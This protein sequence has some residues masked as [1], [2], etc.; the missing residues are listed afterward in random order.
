MIKRLFTLSLATIAVVFAAFAAN[1]LDIEGA[2]ATV[3]GV[4][5]KDLATGK[6]MVDYN[7]QIAMTP[8]SVTKAV[9]A[10]TA[11][12]TLGPDFRF[13][14]RVV[15]SGARS[16]ATRHR[17]DGNLVIKSSGDPT[18]GSDQFKSTA[19]FSDSIVA[20]LKRMGITHISG[21]IVI[22]ET[23]KDAGPVTTWQVD[24][25]AWPYGAGLFGFNWAGNCVRAYPM[26]GTTVP[27]SNLKFDVYTSEVD[28]TDII[29]GI[30]SDKVSIGVTKKNRQ[31]KAWN[32]ETTVPDPSV[33]YGKI[34][35][36]RLSAAG[37][38]I[39]TK[40]SA[41]T[42]GATIVYTYRSPALTDICRN[43][44]KRSDNLFA[45]GML[46]ALKPEASRSK[47]IAYEKDF[48]KDR[49]VDT[50]YIILQDGSG[51][52]RPNRLS[53]RFLG[54]MLEWMARSEYADAYVDFFPIAGIDGT[55]K[56]FAEKT[57]LKGRLAMKTG[58]VNAVQTYAGYKIDAQGKPTH[59]VVVMVNGFFCP[60]PA[61]RR[62]IEKLLLNTL[63]K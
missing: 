29:R 13:T 7:S 6:V 38:T 27:E 48:W 60:R 28:R 42:S 61:L 46:R 21:A 4:Y 63:A 35:A 31:N 10:A 17:W 9:T 58:S 25:L 32:I 26:R 47:C 16:S 24:D 23:M 53:P 36:K 49:G 8:A 14:T 43:L 33:V 62:Q 34:L 51:L 5:I 52:S 12:A 45:E 19:G 55:L 11:L 56:S 1:V 22:E 44:M 54:N 40:R 3:V 59:V 39:G 37:I 20:S 18:T 30:N 2:D 50:R 57:P 41:A 15:L